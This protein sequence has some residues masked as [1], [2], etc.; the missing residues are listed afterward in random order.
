MDR[1]THNDPHV[2]KQMNE[3]LG[4]LEGYLK[5]LFDQAPHLPKEWHDMIVNIMPFL[6]VIFGILSGVSFLG[7]L[8]LGSG[9]LTSFGVLGALGGSYLLSFLVTV[10][11]GLVSAAFLIFSFKGLQERS[12]K[13]WNLVFYSQIVALVGAVLSVVVGHPYNL[14]DVVLGALV[15]FYLLFEVRSYYR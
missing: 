5:K 9:G 6:A 10:A 8:G 13:G 4:G 11:T 2:P 7:L 3:A 1:H 14:V 12:K 15:S